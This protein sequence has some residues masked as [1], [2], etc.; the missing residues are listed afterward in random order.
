MKTLL[1]S[2]LTF[3]T[4]AFAQ[5]KLAAQI[6]NYQIDQDDLVLSSVVGG[7]ITIDLSQKLVTLSLDQKMPICKYDVCIQ[8]MPEP[9]EVVLPLVSQEITECGVLMYTAQLD[10]QEP[11]LT[12]TIIVQDHSDFYNHCQSFVA[13]PATAVKYIHQEERAL[14]LYKIYQAYFEATKLEKVE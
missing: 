14:G 8:K 12:K 9:L 13:V 4:P 7:S 3:A 2:L 6:E 11:G 1:I 10:T 5:E